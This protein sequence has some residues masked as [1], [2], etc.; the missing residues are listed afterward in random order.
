MET[1][2]DTGYAWVHDAKFYKESAADWSAD[3]GL[4]PV[5]LEEYQGRTIL[6]PHAFMAHGMIDETIREQ[7][8]QEEIGRLG[9]IAAVV[10]PENETDV[11]YAMYVYSQEAR[12]LYIKKASRTSVKM[13]DA[14]GP[15]VNEV[16]TKWSK[17]S[18]VMENIGWLRV[19]FAD[20]LAT[21]GRS[22]E[23][24]AM[25]DDMLDH[26]DASWKEVETMRSDLLST[27]Q[28][29]MAAHMM[30]NEYAAARASIDK[31]LD[32]CRGDKLCASN[33][34]I[35]YGNWSN[36]YQDQGDWQVARQ[37]LQDCLGVLPGNAAC[38]DALKDLE[39]RHQF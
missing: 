4:R 15:V 14:I 7:R 29:V 10:A 27:L 9:E 22:D 28:D 33:L 38:G 37:K 3:R 21:V 25:A 31:R 32:L 12:D 16:A 13:F 11:E 18:K 8:T 35:L 2:T 1:T 23:A 24:V 34:A 17:N 39:S 26:I 6:A 19:Y 5:T 30:K 20:A 36:A